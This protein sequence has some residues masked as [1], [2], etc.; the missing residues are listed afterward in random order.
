MRAQGPVI[1]DVDNMYEYL[2]ATFKDIYVL[3]HRKLLNNFA[4]NKKELKNYH[5]NELAMWD[6]RIFIYLR[7]TH[8]FMGVPFINT[9]I[10]D[11]DMGQ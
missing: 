5:K 8:L 6:P 7:L 1:E 3:N 10:R 4:W 2:P 9:V 11:K